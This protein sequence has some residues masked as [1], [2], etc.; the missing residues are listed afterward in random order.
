LGGAKRGNDQKLLP[1]HGCSVILL[2][3]CEVLNQDGSE[4]TKIAIAHF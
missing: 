4:L 1:V 3:Q 2:E